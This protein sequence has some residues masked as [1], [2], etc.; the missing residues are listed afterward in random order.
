MKE[1]RSKLKR[2]RQE[3]KTS[4]LLSALFGALVYSLLVSL[5]VWLILGSITTLY[6]HRLTFLSF[7]IYVS[8]IASSGVFWY[9]FSMACK[10][11]KPDNSVDFRY[12]SVVHFLFT[13]IPLGVLA[14]LY[15]TWLMPTIF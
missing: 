13:Q 11:K 7:L 14:M 10:L 2:L 4:E 6:M 1:Y 15:F 3:Y 12:L 9:L 8:F 5:P